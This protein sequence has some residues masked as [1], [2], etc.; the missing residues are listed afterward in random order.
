MRNRGIEL[1]MLSDPHQLSAQVSP[2]PQQLALSEAH[3]PSSGSE[4]DME[5]SGLVSAELELV[6]AADGVPGW[7][8]PACLA[9]A[10]L[11][12]VQRAAKTHRFALPQPVQGSCVIHV[13]RVQD[14]GSHAS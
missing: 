3:P 11:N 2:R 4:A 6:L 8:A 13:C 1:F 5:A 12:L 14:V 9:A 7:Q 10:H